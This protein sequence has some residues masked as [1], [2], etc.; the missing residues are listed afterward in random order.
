MA[1]T[2]GEPA[3]PADEAAASQHKPTSGWH[4]DDQATSDTGMCSKTQRL[5]WWPPTLVVK[6][7]ARHRWLGRGHQSTTHVCEVAEIDDDIQQPVVMLW[8]WPF[9]VSAE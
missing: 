1:T 4:C 2:F 7:G 8:P 3:D 5:T 6:Q 9:A